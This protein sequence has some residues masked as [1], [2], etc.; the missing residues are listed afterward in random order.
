MHCVKTKL[1]NKKNVIFIRV[2]LGI[3]IIALVYFIPFDFKYFK[4]KKYS[5]Y[6][7]VDQIELLEKSKTPDE[8]VCIV[9]PMNEYEQQCWKKKEEAYS[10]INFGDSRTQLYRVSQ[11][12]FA[13]F[14]IT[15]R[16]NIFSIPKNIKI[17]EYTGKSGNSKLDKYE[18]NFYNINTKSVAKRID[19]LNI[20]KLEN[21]KHEENFSQYFNVLDARICK[22]IDT[23]R[24][25]TCCFSE[26]YSETFAH[27]FN[28]KKEEGKAQDVDDFF[29]DHAEVKYPLRNFIDTKSFLN[30]LEKNGINTKYVSYSLNLVDYNNVNLW[31]RT[32]GLPKKEARLYKAF[33]GL[34][35]Y[36]GQKDKWARI[37]IKGMKNS[38]E[39]ANLFLP[40]SKEIS[41]GDGVII[42]RVREDFVFKKNKFTSLDNYF[43]ILDKVSKKRLNHLEGLLNNEENQLVED[44]VTYEDRKIF[45]K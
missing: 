26:Y 12:E 13:F 35:K 45:I 10:P 38:D 17:N 43:E 31:I 30:L 1:K 14:D 15:Y 4:T 18:L 11:D 8:S 21:A 2:F 44:F 19:F 29:D 23:G 41:Y 24:L 22:N 3:T 32:E 20:N 34:K 36:I 6:F 25:Y 39:V 16:R 7:S 37:Y 40:E 42:N 9:T 28:G 27:D 33:P 5:S